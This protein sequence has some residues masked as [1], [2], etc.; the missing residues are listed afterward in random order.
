M[1]K[2]ERQYK[3]TKA[4]AAKFEKALAA[5]DS[6]PKHSNLPPILQKAERDALEG[7]LET[8]RAEIE[9]YDTIATK[10]LDV[11]VPFEELA[12]V[13]V[14]ARIAARL[15]QQQLA[16]ILH[17]DPQQIQR[18]E[19]NDYSGANLD[20]VVSIARA[21]GLTMKIAANTKINSSS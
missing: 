20:R 15:S 19:A 1:I 11:E 3:I 8:L 6:D 9:E 10:G 17:I 13:L 7:Q 18:Y 21:V 16:E 14:K 2:N 5:L 12:S 4:Q